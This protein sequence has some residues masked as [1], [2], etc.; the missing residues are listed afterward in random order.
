M[1]QYE[2]NDC[3]HDDTV[4]KNP[5]I[6][7]RVLQ[8]VAPTVPA[9]ERFEDGDSREYVPIIAWALVEDGTGMQYLEGVI[10]IADEGSVFA[11]DV[12]FEKT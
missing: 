5:G 10:W 8:I 12:V 3:W 7:R 4:V 1:I 11:E 2:R 9:W 6:K